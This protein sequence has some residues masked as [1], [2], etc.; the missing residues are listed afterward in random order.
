MYSLVA[1]IHL[2]IFIREFLNNFIPVNIM[3]GKDSDTDEEFKDVLSENEIS[4][5]VSEP[6]YDPPEYDPNPYMGNV[7]LSPA[8]APAPAPQGSVV[9]AEFLEESEEIKKL[10]ERIDGLEEKIRICCPEK[11]KEKIKPKID[12]KY[13]YKTRGWISIRGGSAYS[14]K[15]GPLSG[16]REIPP[17]NSGRNEVI[18]SM[19]LVG[20]SE[21]NGVNGDTT[22]WWPRDQTHDPDEMLKNTIKESHTDTHIASGVSLH[23]I[24]KKIDEGFVIE[25]EDPLDASEMA[26]APAPAPEPEV[27]SSAPIT[28]KRGADFTRH[29]AKMQKS[30]M[31]NNKEL[32][33]Y[34]GKILRLMLKGMDAS[35][36]GD[37]VVREQRLFSEYREKRRKSGFKKRRKSKK[38]KSK[39]NK[40]TSKK[41]KSKRIKRSSKKKKKKSRRIKRSSKKKI[42]LN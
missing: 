9:N 4:G 27:E 20:Y 14:G 10:N 22:T 21:R 40:R 39:R 11:E 18:E 26:T 31:Y 17:R 23:L 7:I 1:I 8:P 28:D 2:L 3:E 29:M 35:E 13:D 34:R 15:I 25:F 30:G 16:P 6:E 32:K 41:K 5:K 36:A 37:T 19:G 33:F 38:K 24:K 42:I 12:V